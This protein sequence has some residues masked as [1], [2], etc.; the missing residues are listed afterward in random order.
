MTFLVS[1]STSTISNAV[2]P[3]TRSVGMDS[4][5]EGDVPHTG[6]VSPR[7]GR[8]TPHP[9]QFSAFVMIGTIGRI[10]VV[11]FKG[12]SCARG[13][14]D[15]ECPNGYLQGCWPEGEIFLLLRG[16]R[17][18]RCFPHQWLLAAAMRVRER[19][20][21]TGSE[22]LWSVIQTCFPPG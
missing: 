15:S 12:R 10:S 7:S 21:R 2:S 5:L 6:H 3:A 1:S 22:P 16:E 13:C 20:D 11:A 14:S 4:G 18:W 8:F 17:G 19:T 9:L